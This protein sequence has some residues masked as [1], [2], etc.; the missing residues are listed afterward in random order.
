[1]K[2][3][4]IMV[5]IWCVLIFGLSFFVSTDDYPI[6]VDGAYITEGIYAYYLN[7]VMSNLEQYEIEEN[8]EDA[9]EEKA[10]ELCMEY[11]AVINFMADNSISLDLT[12]KLNVA[13]DTESIWAMFGEFYNSIGTLKTDI[14][15]IVTFEYSKKRLV[16]YYYGEDGLE[17]VDEDTIL[18]KYAQMYV[19][20]KSIE[21]SL[22][23]VSELGEL[24]ELTDSEKE[25]IETVFESYS[26]KINSATLTIDGA[27]VL[28]NELQGLVTTSDLSTII[29]KDENPMYDEEF[30]E[31]VCEIDDGS[32]AVVKTDS[33]YYLILKMD[34]TDDSTFIIY[35]QEVLFELK[36]SDIEE[37]IAELS[38][39]FSPNVNDS[40]ADDIYDLVY[41][42]RNEV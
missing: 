34:I 4:I 6:E 20:F 35:S 1:M 8:D 28:Y 2:K 12:Y 17:P 9:I 38:E 23:K 16:N 13:S 5:L 40:L 39:D 18:E 37:K 24:I 22:T 41:S 31:M 14:T 27:N 26:A 29:I 42:M 11:L 36:M 19:G 15:R 32:A 33:A 25:N 21:T 30:F 10:V 7:D 3:I